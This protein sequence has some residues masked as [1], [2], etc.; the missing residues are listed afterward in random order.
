[1]PRRLGRGHRPLR[2]AGPA[3]ALPKGE[4]EASAPCPIGEETGG[5]APSEP[6]SQARAEPRPPDGQRI[7]AESAA[8][9]RNTGSL[10]VPLARWGRPTHS[11]KRR[12]QRRTRDHAR[13]AI[14][15]ATAS[16]TATTRQDRLGS[17]ARSASRS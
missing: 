8:V 16:S 10:K 6:L 15:S 5:E 1:R 12:K 13:A 4:R 3:V 11:S 9:E 7:P 2:A 17:M 14:A